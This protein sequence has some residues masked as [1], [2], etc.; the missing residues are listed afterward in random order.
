MTFKLLNKIYFIINEQIFDLW[1]AQKGIPIYTLKVH[2]VIQVSRVKLYG[3]LYNKFI[4]RRRGV[5][6]R[7]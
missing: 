2:V 5:A 7:Y 1:K 3:D 4:N 6:S